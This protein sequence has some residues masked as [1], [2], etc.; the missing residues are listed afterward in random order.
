MATMKFDCSEDRSAMKPIKHGFFCGKCQHDVIDFTQWE[1]QALNVHLAEH[2]DTC[3]LYR[4][5]QIEP[6]LRPLADLLSPKV[7]ALAASLFFAPLVSVAHEVEDVWIE[8]SV[9]V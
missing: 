9:Q 6:Q 1:Q 3:G 8:R 5:E 2:P 7:T 4:A